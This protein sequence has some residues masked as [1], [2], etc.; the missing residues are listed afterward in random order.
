[1][2]RRRQ[3]VRSSAATLSLARLVPPSS[4][5]PEPPPSL[6]A[7]RSPCRPARDWPEEEP[8]TPDTAAASEGR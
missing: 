6:P 2:E 8:P 7:S 5:L 1:M 4:L 3:R